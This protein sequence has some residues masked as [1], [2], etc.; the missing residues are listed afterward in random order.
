VIWWLAVAWFVAGMFTGF[1]LAAVLG[2]NE[3]QP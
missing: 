1:V 3:R 2:E